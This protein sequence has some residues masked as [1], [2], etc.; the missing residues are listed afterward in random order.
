MFRGVKDL[1]ISPFQ[2]RDI[3]QINQCRSGRKAGDK[4]GEFVAEFV[5]VAAG[6]RITADV[7]MGG[8]VEKFFSDQAC[9]DWIYRPQ[10]LSEACEGIIPIDLQMACAGKSLA[11]SMRVG[12]GPKCRSALW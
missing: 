8:V 10:R 11:H 3:R 5:Q 1:V 7:L 2:T 6:G 4:S 9:Y 12:I